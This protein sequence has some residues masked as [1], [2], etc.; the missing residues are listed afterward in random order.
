MDEILNFI[1]RKIDIINTRIE[2]EFE[3]AKDDRGY[4][5]QNIIK[6]LRDFIEYIAFRVYTI[7][8]VK[9]YMEYN[10]ENNKKAIKYIK[11]KRKHEILR[12]F[13]ALLEIGPS[14]NSY[15]E[16]G[17]TRLM[18]KYQE[19]LIELKRYYYKM[20]GNKILKNCI[21]FLYII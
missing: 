18:V 5:S 14:H 7:E 17:S 21:N 9:D 6:N 12:R 16:D 10:H 2:N 4:V 1:N 11:S 3:D 15:N 13:H 8:E 19:Y 20:F